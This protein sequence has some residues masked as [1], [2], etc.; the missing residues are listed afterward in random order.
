MNLNELMHNIGYEFKDQQLLEVALTH[1]SA[2]KLNN[3]RLEFFGDSILS[4]VISEALYEQCPRA[5]EG[6]LS[7]LR[8]ALVK[9]DTLAEVAREFELGKFLN[10]G[11][12][13]LKSGGHRRSSIL[14][15]AFEALIAAIH[16]DSS[17]ETCRILIREWFKERI[18][19]VSAEKTLKDP[20]SLLQEYLQRRHV[21]LPTYVVKTVE[22]EAHDQTFTVE[23][24]VKT[25]SLSSQGVGPSRRK[26]EQLAAQELLKQIKETVN[27]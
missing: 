3:E 7:R 19:T 20:K 27:E 18:I 16:L 17:I 26:A 12:G 1:R 21:A 25:L 24:C 13:E 6:D 11:Q 8:S 10:L 15:D 2:A 4:Y 23:C 9:G 5:S 14:A 22:G